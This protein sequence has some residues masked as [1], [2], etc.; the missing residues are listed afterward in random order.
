MRSQ[1]QLIIVF[2]LKIL[3]EKQKKYTFLRHVKLA[4]S[5]GISSSAVD[6]DAWYSSLD[7]LKAY[8][9][10]RVDLGHNI[11]KESHCKS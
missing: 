3:T 5:R 10:T 6:M 2:M 4:K 9:F 11:K 1:F 7:N 8:S